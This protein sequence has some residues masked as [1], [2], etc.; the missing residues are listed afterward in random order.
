MP[1]IKATTTIESSSGIAPSRAVLVVKE[2]ARPLRLRISSSRAR[3][4]CWV[5]K[6]VPVRV[7]WNAANY[8]I[9]AIGESMRY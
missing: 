5:F 7:G 1:V 8:R 6:E 2:A 4:S 3:T 9:N